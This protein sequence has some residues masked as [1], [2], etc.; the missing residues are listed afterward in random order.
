[1]CV[2]ELL[3]ERFLTNTGTF[4]RLGNVSGKISGCEGLIGNIVDSAGTE[5]TYTDNYYARSAAA[6]LSVYASMVSSYLHGIDRESTYYGIVSNDLRFIAKGINPKITI[7]TFA[8]FIDTIKS[9]ATQIAAG[10]AANEVW[11]TAS[12]ATLPDNV[13]MIGV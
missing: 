2:I 1:M 5:V 13:L 10:A 3:N 4:L 9:G 7:S 11:K 8:V 12:H 6:P